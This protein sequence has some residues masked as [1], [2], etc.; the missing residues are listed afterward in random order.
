[1][2]WIIALIALIC[3]IGGASA[4]IIF[5]GEGYSTSQL[6]FFNGQNTENFQPF[7]ENYWNSYIQ[8]QNGGTQNTA[9]TTQSNVMDIWLNSFPLGFD[10]QVQIK[11]SSFMSNAPVATNVS[12][13]ELQS[14]ALKRDIN[15]NFDQSQSWKYTSVATTASS[16]GSSNGIPAK[17]SQ[18]Q[19]ISQGIM[20]LF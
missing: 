3:L 6:Q 14:A 4:Q 7:V 18:G 2:R 1:M 5:T 19:I 10:K 16:A 15:Y 17:D 20:S 13:T 9:I 8:N 12:N 11:N